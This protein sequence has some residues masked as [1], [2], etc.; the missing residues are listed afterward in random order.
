VRVLQKMPEM[1][2]LPVTAT[3]FA[4]FNLRMPDPASLRFTVDGKGTVS[5]LLLPSKSGDLTATRSNH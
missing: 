2:F 4:A 1:V 3:E 5:R